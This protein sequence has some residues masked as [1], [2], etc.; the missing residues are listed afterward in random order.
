MSKKPTRKHFPYRS[1]ASTYFYLH[2]TYQALK[3]NIFKD[4]KVQLFHS[5]EF[6]DKKGRPKQ[7]E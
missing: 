5:P 7:L 6:I 3:N 2:T 4:L 1:I